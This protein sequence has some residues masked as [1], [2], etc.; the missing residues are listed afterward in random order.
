MTDY[1]QKAYEFDIK[2]R[3]EDDK[4]P[5]EGGKLT[6]TDIEE[7]IV[8]E[9]DGVKVIAF[10][11]DHYPVVPAFGYRIEYA[12]HSVVLGDTRYSENLIKFA[13]VKQI[14]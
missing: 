3:I 14:Y 2:M 7:G 13:K 12:G 5:Q 1:L 11:V 4:S 10:L 9:K 8:Y 6:T